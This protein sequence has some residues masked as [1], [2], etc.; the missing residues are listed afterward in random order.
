[1]IGQQAVDNFQYLVATNS[2]D[3]ISMPKLFFWRTSVQKPII[4]LCRGQ[5]TSMVD[6]L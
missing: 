3:M 1:M 2:I 6:S 4:A 5:A